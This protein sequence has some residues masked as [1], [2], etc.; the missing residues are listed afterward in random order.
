VESLENRAR[1]IDNGHGRGKKKQQAMTW[2]VSWLKDE[3][4]RW[5]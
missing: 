4:A 2:P 1:F 3:Y 5:L